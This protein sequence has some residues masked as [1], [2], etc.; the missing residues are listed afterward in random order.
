MLKAIKNRTSVRKYSNKRVED[1]K[2]KSILDA[3]LTTATAFNLRGY[4][5]LVIRKEDKLQEILKP[6]TFNQPHIS[7]ASVIIFIYTLEKD[8]ITKEDIMN[9]LT[10]SKDKRDKNADMAFG[11]LKSTSSHDLVGQA[12]AIG[13]TMSIQATEEN[14]GSTIFS[15]FIP[16]KVKEIFKEKIG[17][18]FNPILGISLGYKH[19]EFKPFKNTKAENK[20]VFYKGDQN[21]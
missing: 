14:I 7:D 1:E 18:N 12:Y 5:L 21:G 3:G 10:C 8:T 20:I 13:A 16:Q 17:N 11:L 2:L 6:V 4:Q 19:E 9:V 15:G